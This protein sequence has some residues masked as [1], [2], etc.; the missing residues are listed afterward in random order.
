MS[1]T[2]ISPRLVGG[3]FQAQKPYL[4]GI[5]KTDLYKDGQMH[6]VIPANYLQVMGITLCFD[7]KKKKSTF[8][9]NYTF[10]QARDL[11]FHILGSVRLRSYILLK[12]FPLYV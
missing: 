9:D 11:G 12:M 4:L 1:A 5:K 2:A 3:C 6:P 8:T 7:S 10:T